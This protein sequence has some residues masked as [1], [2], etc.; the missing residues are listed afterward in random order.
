MIVSALFTAVSLLGA[1][2]PVAIW[3][4][5]T[6]QAP[7][8]AVDS[9]LVVLR[10]GLGEVELPA[11]GGGRCGALEDCL[12]KKAREDGAVAIG[13]SVAP[14]RRGFLVDLEATAPDG[15][16]LASV[17]FALP[18][19]GERQLP[20]VRAFVESLAKKW[21]ARA[22]ARPAVV[23]TKP[24]VAET[25]EAEEVP[26]AFWTRPPARIALIGGSVAAVSA[27]VL[28]IAGAGVKGQLDTSLAAAP[29][30]LTRSQA[31]EQAGLANGLLT[32]ALLSGLV[33]G[34]AGAFLLIFFAGS[35]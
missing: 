1:A 27:I 22:P 13:V 7:R 20:E 2:P 10:E 14:G 24:V 29:P 25:F 23:V 32:G 3:E 26:E 21:K 16:V 33:S 15:E 19:A 18:P 11:T 8:S 6:S 30:V 9:V 31:L 5:D 12:V 4:R 34:L 17:T 35:S 28:A